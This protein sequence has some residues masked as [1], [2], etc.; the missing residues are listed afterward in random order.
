MLS[1]V[2]STSVGE[3]DLATYPNDVT[4]LG[5]DGA[6]GYRVFRD[7]GG[8]Y[9]LVGE[10]TSTSFTDSSNTTL[11]DSPANPSQNPLRVDCSYADL[12]SVRII[13]DVHQGKFTAGGQLD[14]T[15][16]NEPCIEETVPLDIG[17]P[18]LSLAGKDGE[19]R[20]CSSAT[21]C[22]WSS[23]SPRTTGSS[24]TPMGST[25]T[26]TFPSSRSA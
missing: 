22:T 4:W 18:G 26:M 7:V 16:S 1:A 3:S 13:L 9:E 23:A 20:R 8:S 25:T 12:G 11:G 21:G 19:V 5:A 15:D 2:G 14:C 24:W 17:V 6:A 10:T